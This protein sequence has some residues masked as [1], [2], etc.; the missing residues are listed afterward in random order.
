MHIDKIKISLIIVGK[1]PKGPM[2]VRHEYQTINSDG[3]DAH[4]VDEA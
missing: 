3:A 1:D 4:C 2:E